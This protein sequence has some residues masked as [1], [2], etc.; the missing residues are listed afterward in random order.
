MDMALDYARQT[1]SGLARLH[2]AGIVH[3]DMKPF[4]LLLTNDGTVK[5]I[6]FGL[7]RL[8]GEEGPGTPDT[9]KVG[10]PYY[11][12]PEQESD[13]DAA[14]PRSDLFSVAVM[15]YRLL[16][17]RLPFDDEQ[18][19]T[20][21][22]AA[23]LAC[24]V[25]PDLDDPWEDFFCR[26]L[27]GDPAERSHSAL[28]M[29]DALAGLEDHWRRRVEQICRLE[30]LEAE[31]VPPSRRAPR[32]EPVHTGPVP[33]HDVFEVDELARPLA[34]AE[35]DFEQHEQADVVV[36]KATGLAWQR[37]GAPYPLDG[38]AALQYVE[39]LNRERLDGHADWRLP[40][41]DELC[42][43]LRR[44]PELGDFCAEPVFDTAQRILWS[45]DRRSFA[46]SWHVHAS[47]GYVGWQDNTC[48][49]W[50]RAVRTRNP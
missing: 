49:A 36:D 6:D 39:D 18:Q 50:V 22:Q 17:G 25:N 7:S 41:V 1:L 3:R 37:S 26:A 12:A 4:N 34:Y 43:I 29:R 20:A 5:I 35:H 23:A 38:D 10:S 46:A 24:Q 48:G 21:A 15:L 2:Y 47:M 9:L 31:P 13:P 11:T 45:A 42:T 27:A 28:A 16:T 44:P 33:A 32:H 19:R 40:T 8:R 14:G 30:D